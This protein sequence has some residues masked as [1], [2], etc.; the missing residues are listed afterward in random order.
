MD[1]IDK[2]NRRTTLKIVG[3]G[4]TGGFAATGTASAHGGD[5]RIP[6]W[7]EGEVWE[8]AE[9]PPFGELEHESTVPIWTIA[10]GADDKT[11]PQMVDFDL[12]M[13]EASPMFQ[14]GAWG[15]VDF[16]HTLSQ[17]PFSALWHVHFLFDGTA[18]TPYT[19]SDLVNEDQNDDP[20]T[21]DATIRGAT[22]TTEISVP[23]AFN[24]PIRP[25]DENH[26][27]YCDP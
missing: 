3:A 4:I 1:Q 12:S 19:P 5:H 17:N 2:P 24:C 27:N 8:M 23:F 21:D 18:Q 14:D 6:A 7:F 26:R 11:C 22:N 16:D 25:A 9:H 13:V 10:P 20:L 15:S